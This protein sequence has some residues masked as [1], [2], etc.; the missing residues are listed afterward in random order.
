ML[1]PDVLEQIRHAA[2][3]DES[4]AQT[5]WETNAGNLTKAIE[6]AMLQTAQFLMLA[7]VF[8]ETGRNGASE[9]VILEFFNLQHVRPRYVKVLMSTTAM[10]SL[11]TTPAASPK[12]WVDHVR[13]FSGGATSYDRL[14]E[15][16]LEEHMLL[17]P[18][19]GQITDYLAAP[20][21]GIAPYMPRD[22]QKFDR[23]RAIVTAI[24]ES[25]SRKL[26]FPFHC[27]VAWYGLDGPEYA[28]LR[29]VTGWPL[30]L[31]TAQMPAGEAAVP[32]A[33]RE[34]S[35]LQSTLHVRGTFLIDSSAG[36]VLNDLEPGDQ[37]AV[38]VTDHSPLATRIGEHL[39]LHKNGEW[40]STWGVVTGVEITDTDNL[41]I[42]VAIAQNVLVDVTGLSTVRVKA[43]LHAGHVI[44]AHHGRPGPALPLPV[45]LIIGFVVMGVVLMLLL[46]SQS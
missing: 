26:S 24:E 46:S 39:G 38:K 43:Q 40:E 3:C 19:S 45:I 41:R 27:K 35:S 22:G 36:I 15:R 8:E 11:A 20:K 10:G 4:V 37:L 18:I 33:K 29:Q 32:A 1:E 30:P 42:C 25:M 14:M 44:H 7:I 12:A 6:W 16:Q 17:E 28:R 5:A 31:P 9:G 34:L 2:S 13:Q 23:E 21:A